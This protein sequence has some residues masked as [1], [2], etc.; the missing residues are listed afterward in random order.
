MLTD[1][2]GRRWIDCP[3]CNGT[4]GTTIQH[5]LYGKPNC[6]EPGYTAEDC[7]I[8]EGEGMVPAPTTTERNNL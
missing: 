3:R 1:D 2:T 6:P 4:G 8:C 7:H 5:P